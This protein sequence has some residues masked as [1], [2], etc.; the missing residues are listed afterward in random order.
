MAI[1]LAQ[2]S[3][4][5]LG[6]QDGYG[7]DNRIQAAGTQH[8]AFG[9]GN[10]GNISEHLFSFV[11]CN[12]QLQSPP[13][14]VG[15]EEINRSAAPQKLEQ[16]MISVAG[17][18]VTFFKKNGMRA[19]WTAISG[20]NAAATASTDESL[21][22]AADVTGGT[23]VTTVTDPTDGPA[24][25]TFGFTAAS[26]AGTIEVIGTDQ[27]GRALTEVI[28]YADTATEAVSEH[29]Y[30]TVD[31]FEFSGDEADVTLTANKNLNHYQFDIL[32]DAPDPFTIEVVRDTIAST[33]FDMIPNTV[34]ISLGS[35]AQLEMGFIGGGGFP[36]QN[37][38]GGTTPTDI[39]SGFEQQKEGAYP[40]WG[41]ALTLEGTTIPMSDIT[42]N[43]DR[44]LEHP[45]FVNNTR[46]Y[47]QPEATGR[48]TTA[49]TGTISYETDD[50]DNA[51][52]DNVVYDSGSTELAFFYPEYGGAEHQTKITF[53]R[54]QLSS[55][56][57]PE[58]NTFGRLLQT[59]QFQVLP[60]VGDDNEWK[61]EVWEEM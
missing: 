53:G 4:L 46:F 43:F 60:T 26:G 7:Q 23:A 20:T 36:G 49:L 1:Q 15:A 55:F 42:F 3:Y 27:S 13:I 57:E 52:Y 32:P 37:I 28:E 61:V 40:Q 10:K 12:F 34:A 24:K 47:Q 50:Y 33:Y 17:S 39:S 21:R 56:S 31:S 22:A 35:L 2:D 58:I 44:T 54:L 38:A 25:L 16:N 30:Q 6:Q 41:A 19:W 9:T 18:L 8:T 29:Y 5:I 11:N 51:F 48:R 14:D 59:L 45:A